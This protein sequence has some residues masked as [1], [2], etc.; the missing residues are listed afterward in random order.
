MNY[1]ARPKS[2]IVPVTP[3]MHKVASAIIDLSTPLAHESL[4]SNPVG[5]LFAFAP[6]VDMIS[7]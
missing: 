7:I 3:S 2:I 5:R 6:D 4:P 1:V